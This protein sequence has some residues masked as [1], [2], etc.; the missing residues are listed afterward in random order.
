MHCGEI[1]TGNIGNEIRKQFS[2]A[3][4]NVIIAARIEQLNKKFNTQFI[5]SGKF[6]NLLSCKK[7]LINLGKLKL[8]GLGKKSGCIKLFE[9]Y[10]L[11]RDIYLFLLMKF[12]EL[13]FI[14]FKLN[15]NV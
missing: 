6:A 10:Q 4:K 1:V 14:L 13:S 11:Y 15:I 2:L 7:Q 9:L 3:G 5:L 12:V 8:K